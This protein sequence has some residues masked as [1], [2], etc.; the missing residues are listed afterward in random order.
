M[1]LSMK[2]TRLNSICLL[3]IAV[4]LT[5]SSCAKKEEAIPPQEDLLSG[6]YIFYTSRDTNKY[7][8]INN[9]Q[10]TYRDTI[11]SLSFAYFTAECAFDSL[12]KCE[13]YMNSEISFLNSKNQSKELIG[14]FMDLFSTSSTKR[15]NTYTYLYN[16]TNKTLELTDSAK[17][18][19]KINNI[20]VTDSTLQFSHSK[21][22]RIQLYDYESG[23]VFLDSLT[24]NNYPIVFHKQGL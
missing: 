15:I 19:L 9:G 11:Y 2:T 24:F 17:N 20:T 23:T 16:A 21:K 13:I 22:E 3:T 12:G 8:L 18:V 10:I 6:R 4:A 14:Y 7:N 5:I 1:L